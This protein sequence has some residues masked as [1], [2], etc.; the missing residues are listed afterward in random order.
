MDAVK[1]AL[2]D[3]CQR[4]AEAHGRV[5]QST[6]VKQRTDDLAIVYEGLGKAMQGLL[7]FVVTEP[8]RINQGVQSGVSVIT[9]G[10]ASQGQAPKNAMEYRI[11]QNLSKVNGDKTKFRQWNH[12]LKS[13]L[14]IVDTSYHNIMED[15]EMEMNIGN[16]IDEVYDDI[17]VKYPGEGHKR[18]AQDL[19]NII[20]DKVEDEAYDRVKNV[21]VNNGLQAYM[22][23][24]RWF[25]DVSGMGLAE[26][27]RRLMHPDPP[28]D[29]GG[30]ADA[31]EAWYDKMT[32]LETH[33]N[34]Y[35]MAPIFKVNALK[36]LM[37]GRSKDFFEIWETEGG[38]AHD[39]DFFKDLLCKAKDYARRKKLDSSVRTNIQKGNDPMDIDRVGHDF[40]SDDW[41]VQA[42]GGKGRGC[43]T[44]GSSEHIARMCPKGRGK[45]GGKSNLQGAHW[46]GHQTKGA[47]KMSSEEDMQGGCFHCGEYGHWA[48]ECPYSKP[49]G[50]MMGDFTKGSHGKNS[51]CKGKSRGRGKGKQVSEC[52]DHESEEGGFD[53][54]EGEVDQVGAD[55]LEWIQVP[56]RSRGGR[57]LNCVEKKIVEGRREINEVTQDGEWKKIRVQVDSGAFDWVTPK[58][59]AEHIPISETE[60][61]KKGV[62]YSAANGSDIKAF[63][64]KRIKGLFDEGF[65][66]SA[67][68]QVADVRRTLASVMSINRTGNKVVLD[69]QGSYLENKRTGKRVKI[70]IEGNQ[71]V[72]YLWVKA[73]HQPVEATQIGQVQKASATYEVRQWMPTKGIRDASTSNRYA[74]LEAE[75]GID[76]TA[77]SRQDLE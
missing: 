7:Q 29:E 1:Q 65:G 42:V 55:E 26:Q 67:K 21:D 27:A 20:I 4:L 43:W 33:G 58:S 30:L 48:R 38:S 34:D 2:T 6:D 59:T 5:Q 50:A 31:I 66:F 16:P 47:G 32:R 25:T 19:Y 77:F 52:Q 36:F 28:K 45:G 35:K 74:V 70:H 60:A 76:G 12:K 37:V 18:L 40:Y 8:D 9:A 72:F 51:Y 15:M 22:I 62:C 39:E 69:G 75:E 46:G 68:M 61:S 53:I 71:Y 64:E 3:A 49:K 17:K 57:G 23:L 10:A 24:Y 11:V 54:G 41:H 56:K 13:A 73:G 44:C 63:G 14:R